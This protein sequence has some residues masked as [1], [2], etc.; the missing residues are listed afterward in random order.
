[1]GGYKY[2]TPISITSCLVDWKLGIGYFVGYS[3][4]RWIDNDWDLMGSSASDGRLVNELPILGHI[5][6]GVSSS[7]GSTFRR[8]HR[9]WITHF[10]VIS[11]IIR[12][13]WVLIIPFVFLDSYGINFIGNGW[14]YFWLGLWAGL[15][16]ADGIHYYLDLNSQHYGKE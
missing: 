16:H 6:F 7:Y 11:T 10:P 8:Y 2:A 1:M 5:L 15:S 4:H 3:I 9:S 14:H 13:M 12:L